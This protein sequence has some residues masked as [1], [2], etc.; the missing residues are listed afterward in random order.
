MS[1]I[2]DL[3]KTYGPTDIG[4]FNTAVSSNGDNTVVA[5]STGRKIRVVTYFLWAVSSVNC[6]FTS[7]TTSDLTKLHYLATGELGKV[8][9]WNPAGWFETVAG[10]LLGLNI[11]TGVAVSVGGVYILI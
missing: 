9:P 8:Y 5:A 11:S 3:R 1:A 7:S 10:E 2:S 6:K 4:R